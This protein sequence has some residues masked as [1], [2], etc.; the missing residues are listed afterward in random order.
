M[1]IFAGAR[2]CDLKILAEELGETVND[3]HKLKD[4]KK[5]ILASKEYDEESAKEWLNTIINERKEREENER[6]NEEI[7]MAERKLKEEQEIAERRRQDEIQIAE[8][9]RQDEIAERR[10]QDEIAERKRKDEMEFELQKIR[11]E[12]EGRSLNSNSVANQ[13]VN[14][15][16]IKPKLEIHHLMQKFNSDENDISLYLI[17]FE[18]LAKQAE[19]LENTWVTHLLG[20]L[21]YDVAQLIAREPDEI[22]ND[23]GEVKKILLKRS[24]FNEWV[25]GVKAD[26]FEK[27]SDLIITDQIKRKVSQEIKDHFI[28]EWSKLNSPDDLV[29]KLDDYDTLRSTL[30]SKRPRKEWHYDKQD[31]LKDD[32]ALTTNGNK[33]LY[34]ITHNE[35][36]QPKCFNCSKF[37]H[38]SKDCLVPKPLITCRMCN[39]TGHIAKNCVVKTINHSLSVRQVGEN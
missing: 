38:I 7:Q 23:Y 5:M 33:K 6:R 16:Q 27:L 26:N 10:R 2:K 22:A 39:K 30:R 8:Q 19:I 31:S 36:G 24:F 4:L 29:E 21:S 35:R 20:L 11:L 12:T 3:S 1:S 14:S 32:S 15:T 25:N 9:K 13:N 37:G 28:D 34:G 18:R 17:M